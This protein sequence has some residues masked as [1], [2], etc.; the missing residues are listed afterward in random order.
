MNEH[1]PRLVL[2][3]IHNDDG[4]ETSWGDARA[5]YYDLPYLPTAWFDGTEERV[6]FPTV[7]SY[8][9]TYAARAPEPTDVSIDLSLVQV[10]GPTYEATASICVEPE[11]TGKEMRIQLVQVLDY[12]PSAVSYSRNGLKQAATSED[13]SLTPGQCEDV[14]RTFTFDADSWANQE[15]VKIVAWAQAPASAGPAE[16]YQ[17][18]QVFLIPPDCNSN[19]RHDWCDT[20]CEGF[21]G[22][23]AGCG[24]YE[25]CNQNYAP[26]E[27]EPDDDCNVNL[28]Q[29]ICDIAG[30]TSD[31]CNGN[32]VPDECDVAGG[33]SWDGNGN[34]VPDECEP[35]GDLDGDLDVD[36]NDFAT[37]AVCF[38]GATVT[39]PPPGCSP[40]SFA[41][42]DLDG[43]GDVDLSDFSTFSMV[44]TG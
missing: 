38:G 8:E 1:L 20:S 15:D 7:P 27:C 16:V 35:P 28:V 17:A 41:G 22:G 9:D 39:I 26:D 12:W 21:C 25:D 44:Y 34:G 29:D 31:D 24:T 6:D 4:Y 5:V 11:G 32:K 10:S 19:G 40:A 23:V 3:Q 30:G 2:V 13:L 43:D 14:V 36:L 18:A 33:T 42:S 37:F